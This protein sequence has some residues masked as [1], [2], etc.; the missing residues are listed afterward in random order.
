MHRVREVIR[1]TLAAEML[2]SRFDPV[3]VG[4]HN[5]VIIWPSIR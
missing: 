3:R 1:D 5:W 4:H 2:A